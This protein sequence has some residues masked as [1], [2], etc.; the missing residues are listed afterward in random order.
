V[1]R[2]GSTLRPTR[3]HIRRRRG[4]LCC[5][6]A[7]LLLALVIAPTKRTASTGPIHS[8][9]AAGARA[10]VGARR[11]S[12]TG[13]GVAH[14]TTSEQQLRFV[15]AT[16]LRRNY[17]RRQIV[18]YPSPAY[19]NPYLRDSF[20]VAQTMDDRRFSTYVLDRFAANERADGEPPTWFINAYR[21]PQ[22]HDDESAALALIWAWHNLELYHATPPRRLLQRT[23]AY[24]V[25]RSHNGR[26][27]SSP[28][29]YASWWD[30]YRLPVPD[31]LSYNQGLF[32]VAM[33]CAKGLGLSVP[34]HYIAKAENAYRGMFDAHR[35]YLTVS[36]R[37]PASDASALTGE[38]LSMWLFN[39][40]ILSNKMVLSTLRHLSPFGPG[41][42]VVVM[43][44]VN[45]ADGA[46][47][48]SSRQFG[49]PGDYQNGA[50]WLLY[51][52]L[53]IGA[54]GLHGMPGALTR[55]Q[56]RL[57]LEFRYGVILHEYLQT[58]PSLPYYKTEPPWRNRFS[59][60]AFAL[61][62]DRVLRAHER[63]GSGC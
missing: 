5:V 36:K 32:A 1:N 62:V 9:E 24:L 14:L 35:G 42:R 57:A 59:W 46:G 13:V 12:A 25:R 27:I 21:Y 60:D 34:T 49:I 37:I 41:F 11:G 4:A 61:V 29:T 52:A 40:P 17:V 48:A 8:G 51:D 31:T 38:F 2:R 6:T 55:L 16:T 56:A 26:F 47:L 43:P 53:S 10:A 20:W 19:Y 28:G 33:R 54:A 22:Y 39:R 7:C 63:H 50:S 15:V 45:D 58:N 30:A 23:L 44:G 3:T 18:V